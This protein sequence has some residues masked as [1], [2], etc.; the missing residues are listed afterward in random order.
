MTT[1]FEIKKNWLI[2]FIV[3][4]G[5]AICSELSQCKKY[6]NF[7]LVVKPTEILEELENS[8]FRS[9]LDDCD[10]NFFKQN[11]KQCDCSSFNN[12]NGHGQCHDCKCV[13][14]PGWTNYDCS[15]SKK[16]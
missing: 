8:A 6:Q 13:C 16:K 11:T 7:K 10:D 3:L 1:F 5:V 4:I 15:I 14:E 9:D 2:F 12:C